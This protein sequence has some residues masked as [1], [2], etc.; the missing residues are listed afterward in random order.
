MNDLLNLAVEAH[1][2]LK[3]WSRV[4]AVTVAASIDMVQAFAANRADGSLDIGVL[5]WTAG[6]SENF[7][8]AHPFG[9]RLKLVPI[10]AVA[11]TEQIAR[12]T[13]PGKRVEKLSR[14]PFFSWIR[15]RF[16]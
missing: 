1:G 2:G 15:L 16:D 7:V 13:I 6:R 10:A 3:R 14:G 5:P 8:N 11:V 12:C 4:E 9:G